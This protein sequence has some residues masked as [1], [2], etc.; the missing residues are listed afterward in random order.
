MSCSGGGGSDPATLAPGSTVEATTA[1]STTPGERLFLLDDPGLYELKGEDRKLLLA[2]PD[3]SFIYDSAVSR[4][5][6]DIAVAI[7]GPPKQTEAGYDFGV[8]LFVSLDGRDLIDIAKHERIGETM[9]RPNWLPDGEHLIF[10]VL[11]RK[12]SG[13]VDLRIEEIDVKTA[14]RTRL[15]DNAVE[16]SLSPDGSQLA[17]VSYDGQ[18]GAEIIMIRDLATGADH[19]LLPPDQIMSNVANIA[20]S[21]DQSRLVFAAS[22]PITSMAPGVGRIGAALTHPTLRDVWFANL[23]GTGLH[24]LTEIAD[25]SL[26]LAW[27]GDNRNVYAIGDTGFWK[28]DTTDGEMELLGKGNIAGRVQTL[29]P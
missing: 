8:D 3:Q 6:T 28:V 18:T 9:S 12:A 4:D 11:G 1:L 16:P 2:R 26:S 21:P 5:G 29:F 15:I 13:D 24:R 27:S 7:Q 22:D 25:S 23:D 14:K 17:Y 20:W 10:A 19:P